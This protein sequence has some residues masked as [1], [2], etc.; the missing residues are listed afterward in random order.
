MMK[1]MSKPCKLLQLKIWTLFQKG[2]EFGPK[3]LL[4][5][6]VQKDIITMREEIITE[7]YSF[8]QIMNMPFIYGRAM[9][10]LSGNVARKRILNHVQTQEM[11]NNMVIVIQR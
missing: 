9:T 8:A 11:Q 3:Q 10:K 1:E 4:K 7:M 6:K 5:V 2:W